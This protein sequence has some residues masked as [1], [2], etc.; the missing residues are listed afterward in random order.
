MTEARPEVSQ[1]DRG[2]QA[3]LTGEGLWVGGLSTQSAAFQAKRDAEF[4][5]NACVCSPAIKTTEDILH[6]QRHICVC[7]TNV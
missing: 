6:P 4:L 3:P 2:D 1:T 5:T 7:P